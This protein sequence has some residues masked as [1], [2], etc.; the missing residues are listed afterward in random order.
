[1]AL[2]LIPLFAGFL[3][4]FLSDRLLLYIAIKALLIGLFMVV[5]PW[6]LKDVV[7]WIMEQSY[8]WITTGLDGDMALDAIVLSLEGPGAYL[9][10]CLQLPLAFS[11]LLS[12]GIFRFGLNFIPF[13]K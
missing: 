11:M 1:M 9:G 5:L 6:V 3:T 12:A 2:P 13:F 4:K 7:V 10:Q 8:T